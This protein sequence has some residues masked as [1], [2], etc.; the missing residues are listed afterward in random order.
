MKFLRRKFLI[1]NDFKFWYNYRSYLWYNFHYSFFNSLIKDGKKI[2][3]FNRFLLIKEGLKLKENE[4]PYLIFL[5]SMMKV[6]PLIKLKSTYGRGGRVSLPLPISDKKRI[7]F[8]VKWV[9]RLLKYK[10]KSSNIEIS[11]I[12]DLLVSSIYD[13]GLSIEKKD[14]FHT[15]GDSHRAELLNRWSLRKRKIYVFR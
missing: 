11:Q 12:V 8:G 7:V 9:L 4:D 13:K 1:K 3:A 2:F 14:S 15:L 10:N 6:A 5:V